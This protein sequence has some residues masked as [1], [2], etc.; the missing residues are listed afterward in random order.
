MAILMAELLV[1]HVIKTIRAAVQLLFV[2][3][4]QS[5]SQL[6]TLACQLMDQLSRTALNIT[7]VSKKRKN[8]IPII[9]QISKVENSL[10]LYFFPNTYTCSY[11]VFQV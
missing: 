7:V 3:L 2:P 1:S 11:V 8:V 9:R 6:D 5:V 10:F 4:D